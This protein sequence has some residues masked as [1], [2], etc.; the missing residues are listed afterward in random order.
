M[1]KTSLTLACTLI[2]SMAT[3]GYAAD[4]NVRWEL[5]T[6]YR[7]SAHNR[8]ATQ[9]PFPSEALPPGETSAF[10]ETVDEGSNV[11]VSTI[12]IS[13]KWSIA[14]SLA[15]HFK[16]EGI[17]RY[18]RNP[19]SSDHELDVDHLF[20][21]YGQHF[22]AMQLPDSPSYYVQLGK[23]AKFER[24][25]ARGTES[26]G[27]V[28]TAFNRLEDS[29]IEFGLDFPSGLYTK[30]SWTTGNPVFIRDPNALA[31]DNG[32]N[33]RRDPVNTDP[34]LKS[35]IVILYDAEIEDFDLTD[36]PEYGLGLGYRWNSN[37]NYSAFDSLLFG[38][39]RKLAEE[40]SLH[41]TFYGAD[42]DL[43]DLGEVPGA[44]DIK[45]P[46]KNNDKSEFGINIWYQY[47]DFSLF[48]QFVKQDLAGLGRLGK[49][50][51]FSYIFNLPFKQFPL[52]IAPVLRYS[53]LTHDFEGH[54]AYP[55][56]S[57]WWDW[58]KIDYG[59]NIDINDNIRLTFEFADNRF[60]RANR[61]ESNNETLVTLR[62][63]YQ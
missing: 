6:H 9:F 14:N 47:G 4:V 12:N 26:Y 40:R 19:T 36:K 38:Y 28:S 16:I 59:I 8:F 15:A 25:N 21:R 31:G 7:H 50:I 62:W 46:I 54:P 48:S 11:E 3:T 20:L 18:E 56:P 10:L 33:D 34:S 30:L 5:K 63:R 1:I 52:K 57:V 53:S 35:G 29:G 58:E 13:G 42:L 2:C 39:Q 49:E 24:Q 51:E 45:L 27:L 32:T 23:F 43:L 60:I 17:D 44:G 37:D 61:T 41:G 22:R 55:A